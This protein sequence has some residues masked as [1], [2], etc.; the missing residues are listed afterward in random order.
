MITAYT[1]GLPVTLLNCSGSESCP[2]G[3]S[4]TPAPSFRASANSKFRPGLLG[5][6]GV[7]VL[8]SPTANEP[9][10]SRC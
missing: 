6:S 8:D 1:D 3:A 7:I 10:S 4:A 2:T 9:Y 5:E